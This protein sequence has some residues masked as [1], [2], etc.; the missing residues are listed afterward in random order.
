MEGLEAGVVKYESNIGLERLDADYFKK[1]ILKTIELIGTRSTIELEQ[2]C[3]VSDGNH[4]SIAEDYSA[5]SGVRYLRGQDVSTSMIIEE[6][7]A[8]FIPESEYLK[9]KRSH[10][11]K[12]DILITIVGANTGCIGL[13]FNPPAKLTANCKLGIIRIANNSIS[14]GYLYSYLISKFGQIQIERKIRGGGQSGLLLLDLRK[15]SIV[16]LD[17]KFEKLISSTAYRAHQMLIEAEKMFSQAENILLQELGLLHWQPAHQNHNTKSFADS[18]AATGRLDAE[19][20]QPKYDEILSLIQRFKNKQ[21]G[22]LVSIQKSIE[23]GSDAYQQEGIPFIRVA[24]LSKNG[25]SDTEIYLSPNDFGNFPVKPKKDTILLSKD[26][27]VGI[28]YKVE[29][30]LNIITSGAILHLTILEK[31]INPDYLTLVLNSIAVKLQAERDAGGSIIQHWKPD[32]IRKVVIPIL[33]DAIQ[34]QIAV[35]IQQSFQLQHQ[36]KQ[37]LEAAKTAVE[38]AIEKSEKDALEYLNKNTVD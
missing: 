32:E 13:V 14:S 33:N 19:Y 29:Q 2:L 34:S 15:L 23:P 38:I 11:F 1:R 16:R 17:D 28:A 3:Y 31:G 21:L 30:D 36:S 25:I 4:M 37:L 35:K 8:V 27:S 5:N 12:D 9:L 20:Y 7:N 18:L 10:I 22:S 6:R 26:G 24:N